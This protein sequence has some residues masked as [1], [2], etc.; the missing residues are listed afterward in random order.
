ML[1][2]T[3]HVLYLWCVVH[4][5][6][7]CEGCATVFTCDLEPRTDESSGVSLASRVRRLKVSQKRTGAEPGE[8]VILRIRD[9]HN[10]YRDSQQKCVML[11]V[12]RLSDAFDSTPPPR[13]A[14]LGKRGQIRLPTLLDCVSIDCVTIATLH[15]GWV[16]KCFEPLHTLSRCRDEHNPHSHISTS[17]SLS[18]PPTITVRFIE[19]LMSPA[20]S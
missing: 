12:V 10:T 4:I 16:L 5:V 8:V 15:I 7:M 20:C 13:C 11:S 3:L 6:Y 2:A 14:N 17:H 19:V 1:C 9:R 18:H